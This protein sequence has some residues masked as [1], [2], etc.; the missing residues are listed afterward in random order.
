MKS[1]FYIL[2]HEKVESQKTKVESQNFKAKS[3]P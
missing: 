1:N 2:P 3:Q